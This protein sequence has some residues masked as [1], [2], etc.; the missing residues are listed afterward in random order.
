MWA[1]ASD[2]Q[3]TR[4]WETAASGT[5]GSHHF[6]WGWHGFCKSNTHRKPVVTPLDTLHGVH[7]G[8][9]TYTREPPV[10]LAYGHWFHTTSGHSQFAYLLIVALPPFPT[11]PLGVKHSIS[12]LCWASLL[13]LY[14]VSMNKD[15]S[16]QKDMIVC[17]TGQAEEE[18]WL[19]RVVPWQNGLLLFPAVADL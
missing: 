18:L 6:T 12:D 13:S 2:M 10:P 15:R 11:L 4:S 5:G 14:L 9:R 8:A 16:K 3:S 17:L 1:K 19:Q 7:S